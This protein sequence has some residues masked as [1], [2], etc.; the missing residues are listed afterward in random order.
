MN[1]FTRAFRGG[2]HAGRDVDAL[3][4]SALLAVLDRDH[5]AAEE[6]LTQAIRVDSTRI[7]PFV[8]LARLYR[9][10]GEVGRAIRIHQNL[11]LRSDLAEHHT[12]ILLDLAADYRQGGFLRRAI[13]TYEEVLSRQ[14]RNR[15]ALRHLVRLLADAR[16]FPRAIELA[17]RL[18]RLE[19][20]RSH[21]RESDLYVAM[22]EAAR[23]EGRIDDAR[24]AARTAVKRNSESVRAWIALGEVESERG[25]G[26]AAL[27][28]FGRVPRLDPTA[29]PLVYPRIQAVA[30]ALG[31]SEDY[32]KL[33]K[34]L[35]ARDPSDAAA[36][37]AMAQHLAVSGETSEA[38][39]LLE[40]LA[41]RDPDDLAARAAL[42]RVLLGEGRA[43]DCGPVL[44]EILDILERQQAS[45]PAEGAE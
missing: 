17:R 43:A 41:E 33:L 8:A 44:G 9:A 39:A 1:R 32:G 11:L 14:S 20:D 38:V 12:P 7:E 4:R 18:A 13:A 19:K 16:E 30:G 3:L 25:K 5:D 31:R 28:A 15:T 22:A 29:G 45:L 40:R 10:R 2:A 42:G 27:A 36:G 37:L 34:D 6:C 35:L 26:K 24:K 23:A 21:A